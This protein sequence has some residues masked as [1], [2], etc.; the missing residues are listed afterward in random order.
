LVISVTCSMGYA[1][2][3]KQGEK[4]RCDIHLKRK[5]QK[6]QKKLKRKNGKKKNG[7]ILS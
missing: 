7:D 4:N 6:N 5:N 2:R 3:K 1:T